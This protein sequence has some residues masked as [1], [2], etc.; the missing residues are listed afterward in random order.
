M[1]RFPDGIVRLTAPPLPP[2]RRAA[3][4]PGTRSSC[5]LRCQTAARACG[6]SAQPQRRGVS[7]SHTRRGRAERG[8]R[9]H[10]RVR[11]LRPAWMRE[12]KEGSKPETL[13]F[14]SP[15]QAGL[16]LS[17]GRGAHQ[18]SSPAGKRSPL[19]I[20]QHGAGVA[21]DAPEAGGLRRIAAHIQIGAA[22]RRATACSGTPSSAAV[23]WA[24]LAANCSRHPRAHT[25]QCLH[26]SP[27]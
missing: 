6:V 3:P 23:A 14:S 21:A 18:E 1:D 16:S 17:G 25:W 2:P 11:R 26:R 5:P 20:V 4:R 12:L 19:P 15:I 7:A 10:V 9:R 22:C 27:R 24:E 13:S 8:R